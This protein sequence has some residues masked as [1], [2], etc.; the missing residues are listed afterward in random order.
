MDASAEYVR[1]AL[2][3]LGVESK[4]RHKAKKSERR[5][6]GLYPNLVFSTRE[7]VDRPRQVMVSDM[8]SFFCAWSVCRE[9]TLCFNPVPPFV[10]DWCDGMFEGFEEDV[11]S[12]T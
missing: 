10:E 2:S 11:C 12:G 5:A 6:R 1:R 9:L 8:T 3:C 7:T 4:A